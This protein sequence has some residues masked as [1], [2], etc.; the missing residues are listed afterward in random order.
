MEKSSISSE[1]QCGKPHLITEGQCIGLLP[2]VT[3][4]SNLSLT[5]LQNLFSL[6]PKYKLKGKTATLSHHMP[7]E[8]A[9]MHI[10]ID[11]IRP[12][13]SAGGTDHHST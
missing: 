3:G 1:Q 9:S 8:T 5:E 10:E 11:S 2:V 7:P 12:W 13:N 6:V 4:Q